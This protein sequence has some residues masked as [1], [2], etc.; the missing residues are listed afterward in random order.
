LGFFSRNQRGFLGYQKG[1]STISLLFEVWGL[2]LPD[3]YASTP[4][5]TYPCL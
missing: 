3:I 1:G 4:G 2:N 5:Y